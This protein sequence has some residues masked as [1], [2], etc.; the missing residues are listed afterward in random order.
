MTTP[1]AAMRLSEEGLSAL[2][3]EE[4]LARVGADG[5]VY[6]YKCPAGR[7]TIG[8]GHLLAPDEGLDGITKDQ[9]LELLRLDVRTAERHVQRLV[10]VPLTQDQFDAVVSLV[11]NIGGGRFARSRMLRRLNAGDLEGAIAEWLEFRL[12]GSPPRVLPVLVKRRAREVAR[13]RRGT[14]APEDEPPRAA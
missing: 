2:A 5:L 9:A 13:F 12:G 1:C 7:W 3:E 14:A 6:R 4:G 10:T 11:F 8:Y